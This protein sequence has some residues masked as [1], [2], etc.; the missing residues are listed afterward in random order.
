MAAIHFLTDELWEAFY[1]NLFDIANQCLEEHEQNKVSIEIAK[2]IT[3]SVE[4]NETCQLLYKLACI[5]I[6]HLALSDMEDYQIT[7][8]VHNQ[9]KAVMQQYEHHCHECNA[10]HE[11]V[12]DEDYK[13]WLC[14]ACQLRLNEE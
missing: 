12:F 9:I 14:K 7:T 8:K 1:K 11:T 4:Q 2:A 5:Q 10:I 6:R 13:L 3:Q